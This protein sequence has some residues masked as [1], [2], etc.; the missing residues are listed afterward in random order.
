M[1]RTLEWKVDVVLVEDDGTTRARARLAT[2]N[3]TITGYGTAHCSP[4]DVDVPEI[5]EE[6]AAARAMHSVV[7]QLMRAADRDL[8]AVG[9]GTVSAP[10]YGRPYSAP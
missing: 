5:G 9:A 6:L 3:G 7:R 10:D 4:Q 1:V 8:E 2:G